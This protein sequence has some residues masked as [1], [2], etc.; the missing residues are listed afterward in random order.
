MNI[1]RDNYALSGEPNDIP[2]DDESE[3]HRPAPCVGDRYPDGLQFCCVLSNENVQ[4][5]WDLLKLPH[6]VNILDFL[7]TQRNFNELAM[8]QEIGRS[9]PWT[10]LAS[11]VM[12]TKMAPP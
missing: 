6:T 9:D 8:N 5:L 3:R 12:L 10:G 11:G 2:V 4:F 1:L 7:I